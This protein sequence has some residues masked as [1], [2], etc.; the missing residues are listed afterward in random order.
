MESIE[1]RNFGPIKKVKVEIK[2]V[3]VLIGT[4]SS[5]KSTVAKLICIFNSNE[6]IRSG[7]E[8][9]FSKLLKEYNID[10]EISPK[11]YIKYCKDNYHWI[12]EKNELSNNYPFKGLVSILRPFFED[13]L[14][15]KN[16]GDGFPL[17]K[18]TLSLLLLNTIN[19]DELE[20]EKNIA[21]DNKKAI[22]IGNQIEQIQK[23]RNEI[24]HGEYGH[25]NTVIDTLGSFYMNIRDEIEIFNPLYIPA[26]RIV[27]SMVAESVF[28][29]LKNDVSL[30]KCIKDFGSRFESARKELKEVKIDL[31]NASFKYSD[32]ENIL[33]L[34][35]GASIK[36][37]HASSGFQSLTP[38]FIVIEHFLTKKNVIRNF[39]A[40]EEPELNLYPT[41]QKELVEHLIQKTQSA[42]DK[43]IITT[44]SP[45]V[46]TTLDNLIQAKNTADKKPE[47][48][49]A[50]EELV[51]PKRWLDFKNVS[52]YYFEKGKCKSTLDKESRSIGASNIDD[53][54]IS[55][56]NTYE[57]LLEIKYS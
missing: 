35:D 10:F 32:K 27:L 55:L 39:V 25:I 56:G 52:S 28:G 1:I 36:L 54:S 12:L 26:E 3:N 22:E 46:L 5:G 16:Q 23:L 29:L 21:F 24:N 41:V 53:V 34:E 48:K 50:V 40:V 9:I 11:T 45:Y 47:M 49:G 33:T 2:D 4:T 42:K 19:F 38:L 15:N 14:T 30:A 31:L 20:L 18:A 37:E 44:H 51:S 7:N 43:I 17:N 57:K 8:S 13:L 6:F